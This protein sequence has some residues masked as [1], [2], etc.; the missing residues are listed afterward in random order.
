MSFNIKEFV[1]QPS[2]EILDR[3][4]KEQLV[5]VAEHYEME[6]S[7]QLKKSKATLFEA[8]KTFLTDRRTGGKTR[9]PNY[10]FGPFN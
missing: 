1:A 5:P 8:I 3:C 7:S 4:T 10:T 6:L 9:G 2:G